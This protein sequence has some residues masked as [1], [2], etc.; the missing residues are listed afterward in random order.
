MSDIF[1][2]KPF[3]RTILVR[4]GYTE[5]D[6]PFNRHNI[7]ANLIDKKFYMHQDTIV[8]IK[9]N[10]DH[11]EMEVPIRISVH[12]KGFRQPTQKFQE[13]MT[14]AEAIRDAVLAPKTRLTQPAIKNVRLLDISVEPISETNDHQMLISLS[15]T[16]LVMVS[17]RQAS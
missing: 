6:S 11:Q 1:T 2:V 13:C 9:N 15:F 10:Q 8:G 16:A 7:P 12:K 3:F 17:T 5:H 14:A 4:L